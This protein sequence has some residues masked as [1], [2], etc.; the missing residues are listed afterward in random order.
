MKE[1]EVGS[2]GIYREVEIRPLIK[3]LIA[4]QS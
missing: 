4:Q 1:Y 2:W 3:N